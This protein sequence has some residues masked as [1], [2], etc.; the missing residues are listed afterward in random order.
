MGPGEQ[1]VGEEY[2]YD[3][4]ERLQERR[5][6]WNWTDRPGAELLRGEDATGRT[7]L[8]VKDD[9]GGRVRL[10]GSEQSG[11]GS[12]QERE[13]G[14]DGEQSSRSLGEDGG[15]AF[16]F[17]GWGSRKPLGWHN[18]QESGREKRQVWCEQPLDINQAHITYRNGANIRCNTHLHTHSMK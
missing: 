3:K 4:D 7:V 12:K 8:E 11:E 18:L 15:S 10:G 16:L 13:G 1:P 14:R 6:E 9:R 17:H 2:L 5:L